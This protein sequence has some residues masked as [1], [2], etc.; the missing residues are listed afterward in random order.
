MRTSRETIPQLVQ[1]PDGLLVRQPPMDPMLQPEVIDRIDI[2]LT[3]SPSD[4]GGGV[5]LGR[6]SLHLQRF[7]GLFSASS[8]SLLKK[9]APSGGRVRVREWLRPWAGTGTAS[10]PPKFP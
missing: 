7:G 8:P 5:E 10:I 9:T 4:V 2:R 3:L 6:H 1:E